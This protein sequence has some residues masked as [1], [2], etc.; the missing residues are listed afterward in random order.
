MT[1]SIASIVDLFSSKC[2]IVKPTDKLRKHTGASKIP[3]SDLLLHDVEKDSNHFAK[4]KV[5]E[6]LDSTTIKELKKKI[7]DLLTDLLKQ[8]KDRTLIPAIAKCESETWINLSML[9]RS[10]ENEA[11]L[12]F[13][14][15][16]PILRLF[17]SFW[18]LTGCGNMLLQVPIVIYNCRLNWRRL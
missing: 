11:E 3:A 7:G 1:A 5:K 17:C 13:A 8:V 18:N 4:M 10:I 16:D 15:A 9:R 6:V 14:L 2:Y 12:H